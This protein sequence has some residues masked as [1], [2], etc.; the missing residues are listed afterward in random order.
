[1]NS[2]T[3]VQMIKAFN[4][5][6]F[7]TAAQ[8]ARDRPKLHAAIVQ[9]FSGLTTRLGPEH[10]KERD[11]IIRFARHGQYDQ[12]LK[13]CQQLN[14]AAP[15]EINDDHFDVEDFKEKIEENQARREQRAQRQQQAPENQQSTG[16]PAD[17]GPAPGQSQY[18]QSMAMSLVRRF[19]RDQGNPSPEQVSALMK[20]LGV[21]L[22]I[23]SA[24]NRQRYIHALERQ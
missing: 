23:T 2:K 11:T 10:S 5:K 12:A 8:G 7:Q 16:A 1:M 19:A 9:H 15:E 6:D 4:Q 14:I 21:R 20:F 18:P 3:I 17:L 13:M 24:G 22:P